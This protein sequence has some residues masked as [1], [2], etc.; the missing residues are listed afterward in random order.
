[1]DRIQK[2]KAFLLENPHDSFVQH[3]LA[4]EHVKTGDDDTAQALFESILEREPAYTGSYYHLAKLLE[5]KGD[6][7]GAI[8]VYE[9]GMVETKKTG[10]LHAYGELRSALE[11]LTF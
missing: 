11:E 5:R 4:L 7:A 8:R 2:L 10:D 9:K 1:M 3:A 6:E